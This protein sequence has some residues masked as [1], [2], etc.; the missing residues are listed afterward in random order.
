MIPSWRTL[1]S[2][3]RATCQAA[4]AFLDK[5]LAKFDTIEWALR[6]RPE[7]RIE[8]TAVAHL[9]N[10]PGGPGS[11]EPWASAWSLI[12]ESWSQRLAET[13]PSAGIYDIQTRLRSGD[14]SGTIVLAIASLVEPRLKVESI[15]FPLLE[16]VKK[17][18]YPKMFHHLLSARLTS[19]YLVDLNIL[20]LGQLEEVPFL[21]ALANALEAAVNHGLDTARRIGWDGKWELWRL[22]SLYRIRYTRGG[23]TVDVDSDADSFRGGI[24]PAVKLFHAVVARI[25]ELELNAA[26]PFVQRW[27]IAGSPVHIRLWAET[28]LNPLFVSAEEVGEFLL[29]LD[30]RQFWDLHEF[31][32]IA[33]LRAVRFSELD[34]GT[35]RAIAAR[36]RKGPP[37]KH[38]PKKADPDEVKEARLYWAV[39]ELKRI[40]VAAGS[41]PRDAQSWLESRLGRFPDLVTMAIEEG[42]LNDGAEGSIVSANP[43][44]GYDTLHGA[45]RL[46]AL[47]VAFLTS[48]GWINSRASRATDW[49]RQAERPVLV[50]NDLESVEN[51]GDA[52]PQVWN[53][54]GWAHTAGQEGREDRPQCDLQGEADRVLRLLEKVS[55]AT[56][57][58]AIDG[59]SDWL[60]TWSKQV[61][62]SPSGLRVWLRVWP[63]AVEATNARQQL[64][65]DT[66]MRVLLPVTNDD[67]EP[68]KLD[69]LNSPSGKL[70]GVFLSA[71]RSLEGLPGPFAAGTTQRQMRDAIISATGR[72]D[73]IARHRLIE[74]LPNFLKADHD[75][76]QENLISPLHQDDVASLVLWRA[77]AR[78][79]HF[80]EVLRIIGNTMTKRATDRR[81]A[82]ETR[83]KLVFSLV[84]ESLHAFRAT[85]E[86]AVPN[87]RIQQMLRSVDEEVRAAAA[88]AILSFVRELSK[89]GKEN[90]MPTSPAAVFR[91]A[92]E[93]F[94]QEVWPQERSLA[95]LGV[96]RALAALPAT[97]KEAFVEAVN[98]VERF[99]VPTG[100]S[101]IFDYGFGANDWET[102]NFSIISDGTKAQ[103]FLRLLDLTVGTSESAVIPHGLTDAMGQ[104]R[105]IAPTLVNSPEF[106]RLATAARR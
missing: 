10:S 76:T 105:S 89:S 36:L 86:P 87:H 58:T 45:A 25:A 83:R 101:S 61:V 42:F 14:R 81:L 44:D 103:A 16:F 79:T 41:L 22:G 23:S 8:R 11:D 106:R 66:D 82:R 9:V 102:W 95:T 33:E 85:R 28:E 21:V 98:A 78:R 46:R 15:N 30:D 39:R 13:N 40:V 62:A 60:S 5:R 1:A 18:R 71:C 67:Q 56:L 68:G 4:I 55:V 80:T 75:W 73:L 48:S 64:E 92:A 27:R 59:I 84:V 12:L 74:H 20:E 31:P 91:S 43:D 104:I 37:R 88:S 35:Q 2:H 3:E 99:L 97:S 17:P 70:V 77:V 47:E 100:C 38:W 50:L 26:Q 94:L 93:P 53:R 51:G 7:Q 29:G 57:S 96:S 34:D 54:F 90:E 69:T 52:F 24:A 65:D 32:E 49:L 6:L 72:S 63:L 19:G